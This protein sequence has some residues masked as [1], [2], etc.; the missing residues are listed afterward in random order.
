MPYASSQSC[1]APSLPAGTGQRREHVLGEPGQIITQPLSGKD[2]H[3][4]TTAASTPEVTITHPKV[5]KHY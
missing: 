3:I 5:T 2:V 1:S 4:S